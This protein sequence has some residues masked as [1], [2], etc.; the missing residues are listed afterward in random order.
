MQTCLRAY[1]SRAEARAAAKPFEIEYTVLNGDAGDEAWRASSVGRRRV[2]LRED[3]RRRLSDCVV[4]AN[5]ASAGGEATAAHGYDQA[6]ACATD[7]LARMPAL[8]PWE[9][10][11]G[12]WNPHPILPEMSDEMHCAE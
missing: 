12:V 11:W 1:Y 3:P 6:A 2:R 9:H 10:A 5:D 8:R 7:E 4:S